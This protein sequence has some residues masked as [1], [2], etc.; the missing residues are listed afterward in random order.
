MCVTQHFA[1]LAPCPLWVTSGQYATHNGMSA[2]P[3]IAT[4]KADI[5]A[6]LV[7]N[8]FLFWPEK[9]AAF[10]RKF[11][12]QWGNSHYVFWPAWYSSLLGAIAMTDIDA[13]ESADHHSHVATIAPFWVLLLALIAVIEI[14]T[15]PV[16]R[17]MIAALFR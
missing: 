17:S 6:A 11:G 14:G 4:T 9:A 1:L 12:Q 3:P 2:L 8:L 15:L 13:P 5:V 16:M 7:G 10:T